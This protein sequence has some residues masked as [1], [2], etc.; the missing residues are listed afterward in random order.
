[1]NKAIGFAAAC[2]LLAF[3]SAAGAGR[4]SMNECFEGSEFIGNAALSRDAG[5]PSN[6]FLDRMEEDFMLIRAFPNELRWFVHDL[7]DESFLMQEARDV[8]GTHA[9]GL[10]AV[11][12]SAFA[13]GQ[14]VGP[15]IVSYV[16]AASG[17]FSVALMIASAVLVVS[18]YE[19]S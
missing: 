9:T 7:D 16:V 11:L 17:S 3:A 2:V 15:V 1:M 18:A 4:P 8:A 6:A 5:M 19:L 13:L 12:T 14:I 10:M